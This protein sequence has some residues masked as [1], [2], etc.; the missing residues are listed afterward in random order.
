VIDV[1]EAT[2]KQLKKRL[3]EEKKREKMIEDMI[4]NSFKRLGNYKSFP[5]MSLGKMFDHCRSRA[6]QEGYC[7]QESIDSAMSEV[8]ALYEVSK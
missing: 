6:R 7:N 2:I 4:D 8:I 5:I 3:R 1:D